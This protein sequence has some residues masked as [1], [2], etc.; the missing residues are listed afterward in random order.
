[1]KP[2]TDLC[3]LLSLCVVPPPC[4]G[5]IKNRRGVN[6]PDAIVDLPALSDKDKTDLRFGVQNDIDFVAASF[7]RKVID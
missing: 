1:M 6:L 7:V 5:K 4:S 2:L 3:P